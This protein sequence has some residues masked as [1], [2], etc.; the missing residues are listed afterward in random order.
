MGLFQLRLGRSSFPSFLMLAKSKLF[1]HFTEKHGGTWNSRN[2][3]NARQAE[4]TMKKYN[5]RRK[6]GAGITMDVH[7][8]DNEA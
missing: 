8:L 3:V 6:V 2:G 5:S 7:I 1:V 4:Y